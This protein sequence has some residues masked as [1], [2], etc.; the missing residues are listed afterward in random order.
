MAEFS[1]NNKLFY[2]ADKNGNMDTSISTFVKI[3]ITKLKMEGK[4]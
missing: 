3:W 1:L 4:H 2:V